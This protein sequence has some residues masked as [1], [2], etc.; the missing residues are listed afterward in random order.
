MAKISTNNVMT[1]WGTEIALIAGAGESFI[2]RDIHISGT[3]EHMQLF[4]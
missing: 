2:V 1:V 3:P 4:S